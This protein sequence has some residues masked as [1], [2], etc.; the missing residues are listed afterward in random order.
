M[1]EVYLRL[2]FDSACL[3][4]TRNEVEGGPDKMLRS[5]DGN[6]VFSQT[7]WRTIIT[8]GAKSFGRHQDRVKSVLWASAVDGTTR[9]FRRYY[10]LRNNQGEPQKCF[11]DHEAFLAGDVIGVKALVPDDVPIEDIK[12]IMSVAGEY[13]G[14]SPFGW[15]MGYGKFKVIEVGRTKS[16]VGYVNIVPPKPAVIAHIDGEIANVQEEEPAPNLV[17]ASGSK[18]KLSDVERMQQEIAKR[19]KT[20]ERQDEHSY[21][22]DQGQ[23]PGGGSS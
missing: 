17:V 9:L 19:E 13:F 10:H 7:W 21:T 6:V 3:G 14:I 22:V 2:Q 11:K 18:S 20:K 4:S 15:K 23:P 16:D 5:T 8:Q 1:Y 12:D